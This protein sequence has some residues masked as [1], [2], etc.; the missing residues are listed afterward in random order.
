[1]TTT[2]NKSA[3]QVFAEL[4]A[5]RPHVETRVEGKG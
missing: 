4:S 5:V 2:T 1:M 3:T